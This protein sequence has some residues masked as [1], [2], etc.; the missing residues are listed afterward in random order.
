MPSRSLRRAL[1]PLAVVAGALA[2]AFAVA[3]TGEAPAD[4]GLPGADNLSDLTRPADF[5]GFAAGRGD[6][7][8]EARETIALP[9]GLRPE[10]IT[11]DGER[12]FFVGSLGDGR[13]VRGDLRTGD[14]EVLV[15]GRSGRVAVGMQYEQRHD[16]LWVAGGPTGAVTVYDAQSGEQ[17]GRWLT[18]GSVFLNDVTVT[19]DAAFV[20]DSGMQRLVVVPLRSQGG[21]PDADGATTLPLTGDFELVPNDFNANGIRALDEDQLILVQGNTG[22][23]FLVDPDSG[24]TQAV[25][26]TSGRLE[27]GDGLEL[28]DSRL[29][30]VRGGGDDTVAMVTLSQGGRSAEVDEVVRDLDFD[31]PTT[32]TYAD[33]HLWAVNARFDTEATPNTPYDVVRVDLR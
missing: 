20:T 2:V 29:A 8:C 10:G 27:G 21:L 15:P 26:F 12:T 19:A 1:L 24:S 6:H 30:V 31:V 22:M 33:G 13:V 16:R 9:R 25:E 18:P 32:A 28:V 3:T 4:S 5:G 23:L 11:S 17:L 7:E 14:S